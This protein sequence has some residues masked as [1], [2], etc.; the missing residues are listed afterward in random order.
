MGSMI[1]RTLGRIELDWGKNEGFQ[2]HSALFRP[3]DLTTIPYYYAANDDTGPTPVVRWASYDHRRDC[4]QGH[5]VGK[6]DLAKAFLTQKCIVPDYD[7][8]GLEA[9][10]AMLISEC[11]SGPVHPETNL[12]KVS[13]ELFPDRG[14]QPMRARISSRALKRRQKVSAM[15]AGSRVGIPGLSGPVPLTTSAMVTSPT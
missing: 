5:I 7:Y 14:D 10:L 3:G 11:V 1:H 15:A 8:S 2:D 4:Y 6:E 13:Y 12:P 9:I